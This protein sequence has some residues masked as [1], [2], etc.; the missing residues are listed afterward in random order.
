[1]EY[2]IYTVGGMPLH[3]AMSRPSTK[4]QTGILSKGRYLTDLTAQ[5]ETFSTFRYD[6]VH[7]LKV[8]LLRYRC[9]IKIAHF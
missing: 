7:N 6:R 1:M 5:I 8:R 9:G 4:F 2:T 3:T